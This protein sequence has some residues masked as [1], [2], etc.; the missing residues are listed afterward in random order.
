LPSSWRSQSWRPW[1]LGRWLW[2]LRRCLFPLLLCR[3]LTLTTLSYR[4]APR[5]FKDAA[6]R[7]AGGL[8]SAPRA[9]VTLTRDVQGFAWRRAAVTFSFVHCSDRAVAVRRAMLEGFRVLHRWEVALGLADRIENAAASW[10]EP[11]LGSLRHPPGA[12]RRQKLRRQLGFAILAPLAL[13]NTGRHGAAVDMRDL[14]RQSQ[15]ITRID[16]SGSDA[17]SPLTPGLRFAISETI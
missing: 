5:R 17:S 7:S 8:P 6:W 15:I 14:S 13:L 9:D 12:E 2:R 3:F 4:I 10:E 11:K 1:R 16:T